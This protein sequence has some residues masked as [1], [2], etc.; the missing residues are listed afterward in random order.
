[1]KGNSAKIIFE[2][3]DM[4]IYIYKCACVYQVG[5]KKKRSVKKNRQSV[6]TVSNKT[7]KS[8]VGFL[9]FFFW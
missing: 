5:K 4:S 9:C 2:L 8:G 6:V 1:M 7:N 3:S